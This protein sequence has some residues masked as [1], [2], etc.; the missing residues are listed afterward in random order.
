MYLTTALKTEY[1]T[2]KQIIEIVP[3]SPYFL[4]DC[5]KNQFKSF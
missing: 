4:A 2:V 1:L 5:K 3:Y